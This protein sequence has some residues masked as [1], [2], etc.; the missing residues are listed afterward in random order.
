MGTPPGSSRNWLGRWVSF[1]KIWSG[2][3][4]AKNGIRTHDLSAVWSLSAPPIWATSALAL[5]VSQQYLWFNLYAAFRA[6]GGSLPSRWGTA[7]V[8]SSASTVIFW[9]F[10]G[11]G[12]V[13]VFQSM[14]H[15]YKPLAW[16]PLRSPLPPLH[17]SL[18]SPWERK[19]CNPLTLPET[20]VP[21]IFLSPPSSSHR[22]PLCT[23]FASYNSS[24]A[25]AIWE[26]KSGTKASL[27]W[28][29][30]VEP[31]TWFDLRI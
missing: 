30:T 28:P 24:P 22:L 29:H 23:F 1:R 26:G 19:I 12:V 10:S 18:G 8:R 7:D 11:F 13:R 5:W 25:S 6:Q 16:L 2:Q 4:H 31:D 15:Q 9:V 14:K 17:L 3:T 27:R 20:P 21:L